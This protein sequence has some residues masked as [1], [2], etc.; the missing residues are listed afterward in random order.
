MA[1]TRLCHTL[2]METDSHIL[3]LP[4]IARELRLPE[5]WLR[6]EADAGRIPH[7]RAGKKYRFTRPAVE[8]A[9]AARAARMEARP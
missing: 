2:G 7:L 1:H 3:T 4:E 6:A 8:R 9:L 5:R